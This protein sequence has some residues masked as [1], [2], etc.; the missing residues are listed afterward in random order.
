MLVCVSHRGIA[1]DDARHTHSCHHINGNH[2]EHPATQKTTFAS[3]DIVLDLFDL[4]DTEEDLLQETAGV[5][6]TIP[7]KRVEGLKEKHGH[8]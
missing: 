8:P 4:T 2:G 7:E 3:S 5:V 6:K 1:A